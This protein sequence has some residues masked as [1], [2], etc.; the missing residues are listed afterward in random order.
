M[1]VLETQSTTRQRRANIKS[2]ILGS[3]AIAGMLPIALIAPNVIGA[4]HKLGMLP[5]RRQD[6]YIAVARR[7][8][9]KEGLLVEDGGFL[10]LSPKGERALQKLSPR[11]LLQKPHKWDGKWRVLIFDIPEKRRVARDNIRGRL[12]SSGFIRAQDS[13][14][15]YPYPCEEFVAL[16]KA[17][18]R[19]GKDMLYLIVDTLEGDA[20]FRKIFNL[21]ADNA[22]PSIRITGTAG[23][24]LDVILPETDTFKSHG[25]RN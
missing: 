20:R 14:W 8:L 18:C 19:V 7:K 17:E 3:V 21:S 16:L 24:V 13:V 1:T 11:M 23:K 22:A 4:I 2:M 6:E 15:I 10:R 9:K 5:K 12:R 25:R